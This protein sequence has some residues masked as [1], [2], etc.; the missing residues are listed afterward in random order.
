MFEF[1]WVNSFLV[2]LDGWVIDIEEDSGS[3]FSRLVICLIFICMLLLIYGCVIRWLN[4][5]DRLIELISLF[6]LLSR[7][8][9]LVR[10]MILYGCSMC[11]N[12]LVVKLVL[13]LRNWFL[14]VLFRLVI[15]GMEFVC[16]LVLI[17]VRLMLL[18][19][20]IML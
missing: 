17:G 4:L 14:F 20:L 2:S 19:L 5:V 12:L 11:I 18:I 13:M 3:L 7:L 1:L 9:V 15:I 8:L 16:R 10:N 6:W